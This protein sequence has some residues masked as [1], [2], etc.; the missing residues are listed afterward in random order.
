MKQ[1]E[2][3]HAAGL[4]LFAI[5]MIHFLRIIQGWK[6]AIGGLS[7]PL[8]VSWIVVILTVY[9]AFHAVTLSKRK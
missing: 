1:Q 6:V 9:L 3:N 8:W 2:F 5:G 4:V 7:I